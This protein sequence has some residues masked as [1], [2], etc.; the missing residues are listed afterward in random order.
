MAEL[1][2]QYHHTLDQKNR[3][4]IPSKL[5][6][7]LG[8][9]F[10]LFMAQNGDKC[11]FAYTLEDW[12]VLM[13]KLNSGETSHELT[14]MQRFVHAFSDTVDVDKQGRITIKQN[15]MDFA[16]LSHNVFILGAG[17]RVEI[18]DEDEWNNMMKG[19]A[20]NGELPKINLAF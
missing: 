4:L 18:W 1:K 9:T 2:G 10:I 3:L 19:I 7:I 20:E 14:A 6:D 13:E 12:D 17:R 11:L 16:G 5:R 15:F 8:E